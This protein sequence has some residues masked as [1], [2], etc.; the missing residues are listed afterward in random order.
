MNILDAILLICF[1]PAIVQGIR[2][3][4]IN[5]VIS[6]VSLLLSVWLAFKFS[7][8]LSTYLS[9]F[10]ETDRNVLIVISFT[11]IML[12]VSISFTL[13]GKAV[14]A[15]INF[16]MLGWLNKLLGMIFAIAKYGIIIGLIILLFC[17][18]NTTFNIV[19]PEVLNESVLY[20]PL[21]EA[22]ETLFPYLKSLFT[23]K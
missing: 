8:E 6:I 7:P 23:A 15:V 11:L 14:E 17:S 2:K 20:T 19:N 12:A 16:I 1:I 18:I 10:L 5:Q 13:L 3:G 21:K 9:G 22:A 4:L